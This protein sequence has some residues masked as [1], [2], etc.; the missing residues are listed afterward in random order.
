MSEPTTIETQVGAEVEGVVARLHALS[1]DPYF[2][3]AI[4]KIVIR[5]LCWAFVEEDGMN[6]L[7]DE[8]ADHLEMMAGLLRDDA[9]KKS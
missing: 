7:H 1:G 4:A 5:D 3:D 8:L 6:V 2:R 9:R